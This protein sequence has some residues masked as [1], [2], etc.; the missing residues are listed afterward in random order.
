MTF[1]DML[2]LS[3]HKI[4]VTECLQ[5]EQLLASQSRGEHSMR[6]SATSYMHRRLVGVFCPFRFWTLGW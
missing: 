5:V 3:L 4:E 1:I 6:H 2:A